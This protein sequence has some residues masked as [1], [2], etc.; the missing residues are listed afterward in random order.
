MR[1]IYDFTNKPGQSKNRFLSNEWS[2]YYRR[3][4][5]SYAAYLKAIE[6]LVVLDEHT[7]TFKFK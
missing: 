5:S 1:A 4:Y 7:N 2:K 6:P 3:K